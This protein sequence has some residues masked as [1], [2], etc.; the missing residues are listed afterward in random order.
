MTCR[1]VPHV[2]VSSHEDLAAAVLANQPIWSEYCCNRYECQAA[3]V[4]R[5]EN[6]TGRDAVI[7]QLPP[8]EG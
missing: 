3:A 5:V 8:K 2:R 4:A 6:H 1:H 7:V